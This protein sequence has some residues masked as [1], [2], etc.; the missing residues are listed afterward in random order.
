MKQLLGT[1][2]TSINQKKALSAYVHR[3]TTD[4]IPQWS[5]YKWKNGQ[6]YPLQFKNDQEWLAN[7]YFQ[8]TTEGNL[9]QGRH[10]SCESHPTFPNNPELRTK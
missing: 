7:T 8:V 4:N 2:L 9:K 1:E 5:Q 6:N 3:Y 10:I